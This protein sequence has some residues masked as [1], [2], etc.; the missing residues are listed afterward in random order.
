MRPL[1]GLVA[2]SLFGLGLALSGMLD[3]VRVLGFLD[4]AG[5]W[6]PSLAFVL[7]GAI[8]VSTIGWRYA[9]RRGRPVLAE[10]FDLPTAV[11]IDARL[12]T[13]AALFGLG[14]GLVGLCPGP[15]IAGL[16]LSHPQTLLFTAAMISGMALFRLVPAARTRPSA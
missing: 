6:D 12:L 8:A 7:G 10:R 1:A 5:P 14:W 15:A 16:V 3:P 4:V 13:G 9:R 2:G 11:R